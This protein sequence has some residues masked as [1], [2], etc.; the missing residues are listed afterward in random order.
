VKIRQ[1]VGRPRTR[2]AAV[3]GDKGYSYFR[4]RDW[5]RRHSIRAV[6]ARRGDQ[7][8]QDGRFHF[9]KALYRMRSAVEQCTGWIKEPRRVG[10]RF[11]KLALNFLAM[12]HLAFIERYMRI[13][14][15]DRA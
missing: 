3:A 7:H 13:L 14:F 12:I 1:P 10:T 6:I 9:D 11:E 8:P 4:V 5:L 2:P 15:S